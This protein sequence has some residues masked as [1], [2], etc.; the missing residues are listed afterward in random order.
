MSEN[1]NPGSAHDYDVKTKTRAAR[2]RSIALVIF[3]Y[4]LVSGLA[5]SC[6][7]LYLDFSTELFYGPTINGELCSRSSKAGIG[8]WTE[9]DLFCFVRLKYVAFALVAFPMSTVFWQALFGLSTFIFVAVWRRFLNP[10][11]RPEAQEMDRFE[12]MFSPFA[13]ATTLYLL[14]VLFI[15]GANAIIFRLSRSSSEW[16]E[17]FR[18][19][20]SYI[21]PLD[22]YSGLGWCFLLGPVPVFVAFVYLRRRFKR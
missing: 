2:I 20:S 22:Y 11:S 8:F 18:G 16:R 13:V 14:G 15:S 5:L 21:P 12:D 9:N 3:L 1:E 4:A 19:V 7:V 6:F 10:F 17:T